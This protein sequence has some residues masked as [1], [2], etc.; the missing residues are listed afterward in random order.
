LGVIVGIKKGIT[1]AQHVLVNH[2]ALIGRLVMVD[3]VIPIDLGHG[4]IHHIVAVYTP[5]DVDDTI[6][7]CIMDTVKHI[8]SDLKDI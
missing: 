7:I 6:E 5:W 3:I 4:F 8:F 2:P 1:V